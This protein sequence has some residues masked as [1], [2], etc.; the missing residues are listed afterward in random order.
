MKGE[1]LRE[2]KD[3]SVLKDPRDVTVGN[4]F[5]VYVASYTCNSVVDLDHVVEKDD[6][7]LIAMMD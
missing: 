2:Y 4:N 6:N 5:S 7:L 3:V 1:K